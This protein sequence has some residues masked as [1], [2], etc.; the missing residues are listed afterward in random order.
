MKI[1]PPGTLRKTRW[2]GR[3]QGA[4]IVIALQALAGAAYIA[5]SAPPVQRYQPAPA[6][7]QPVPI[8]D[9]RKG[10]RAAP[11]YEVDPCIPTKENTEPCGPGRRA[12]PFYA[13]DMRHKAH[14]AAPVPGTLGLM[15]AAIVAWLAAR[16]KK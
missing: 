13:P 3:A 5:S 2:I 12:T 10:L 7:I 9:G 8:P 15:G 11:R 1:L 4:A 6:T 14:N 16:R